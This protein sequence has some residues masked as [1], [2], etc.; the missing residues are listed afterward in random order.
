MLEGKIPERAGE[1]YRDVKNLDLRHIVDVLSLHS[2]NC[3]SLMGLENAL[4]QA[5]KLLGVRLQR[6]NNGT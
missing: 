4:N 1:N 6:E 3:T 5:R 2:A